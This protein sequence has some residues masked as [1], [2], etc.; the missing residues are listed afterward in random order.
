MDL[1]VVDRG[2]VRVLEGVADTPFMT[3]AADVDKLIE[4]CFSN[5]SLRALLYS[6]N[7]PPAF[8]DL[9]S[10]EAGAILQKLR[11]Y[12]IR[13]A[14]VVDS[15]Q[16]SFSTRF[17]EMVAEEQRGRDFG[18]FDNRADALDWLTSA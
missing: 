17:G 3:T 11:N 12:R 4:A 15:T 18:I 13:L 5:R 7:L 9:S 1:T 16:P 2:D 10:R 14:V 6:S 8:F